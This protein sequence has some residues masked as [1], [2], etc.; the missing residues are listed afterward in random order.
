MSYIKVIRKLKNAVRKIINE[1]KQIDLNYT[2]V[3]FGRNDVYK[4][5]FQMILEKIS[6]TF[7]KI[8]NNRT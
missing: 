4:D 6:D 1:N 3:I 8:K 7:S 5:K 2:Y